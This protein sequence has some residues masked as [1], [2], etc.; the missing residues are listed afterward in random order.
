[1][2]GEPPRTATLSAW[3]NGTSEPQVL[4]ADALAQVLGVGIE[5]LTGRAPLPEPQ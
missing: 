3:E 4:E 5:V 1:M 2:L